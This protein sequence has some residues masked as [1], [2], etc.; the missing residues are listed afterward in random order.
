MGAPQAV[1]DQ[2]DEAERIQKKITGNDKTEAEQQPEPV[3]TEKPETPGSEVEQ[4]RASLDQL[5]A[6]FKSYKK[7]YDK[8]VSGSRVELKAKE[9]QIESLKS[10][11]D[12]L[13]AQSHGQEEK[14]SEAVLESIS[15]EFGEEF[16]SAVSNLSKAQLMRD[17][18]KLNARIE[19][20]E[21]RL[22][23]KNDEQQEANE[24]SGEPESSGY[25]FVDRLTDLVPNWQQINNSPQF[26]TWLDGIESDGKRKQDHLVQS[27]RKNDVLAVAQFFY[28]FEDAAPARKVDGDYM[29]DGKPG[30]R[31]PEDDDIITQTE[32]DVFYRDKALGRYSPEEAK[33]LEAKIDNAMRKGKI[34]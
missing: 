33:Q 31:V 11:L 27:Q 13:K 18:A 6:R 12:E 2:I 20:I 26:K 10:A 4:L 14:E 8:E 15:N 21:K 22:S 16:V 25:S 17:N 5:D 7:M 23:G 28:D 32:L 24:T 34:R 29:P 30:S 3:K 9:E 19:Q 1:Q